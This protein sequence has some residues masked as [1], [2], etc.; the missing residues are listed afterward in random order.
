MQINFKNKNYNIMLIKV[1]ATA[2]SISLAVIFVLNVTGAWFQIN[3]TTST[4]KNIGNVNI[5]VSAINNPFLYTGSR[6]YDVPVTIYNLSNTHVAV[7]TYVNIRWEDNGPLQTV[8]VVLANA[9]R[10]PST[11]Y[12]YCNLVLNPSGQAGDNVDFLSQID[13]EDYDETQ[14][15][16]N[17]IVNVYVEAVQYANDGYVALWTEAPASWLSI[18]T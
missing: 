3:R 13:F 16:Y 5:M 2:L 12:Y 11:D 15:G 14:V 7:R 4:T 6:F 10:T 9:D 1:V 18:L 17:F 8:N